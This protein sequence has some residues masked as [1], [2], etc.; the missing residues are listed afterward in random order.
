MK[1]ISMYIYMCSF[2][3][4]W[5]KK[6]LNHQ[7]CI[8]GNSIAFNMHTYPLSTQHLRNFLSLNLDKDCH[9]VLTKKILNNY[10]SIYHIS[11][12]WIRIWF[13]IWISKFAALSGQWWR[14]YMREKFSSE[15]KNHKQ[16]NITWMKINLFCRLIFG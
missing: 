9:V 13:I 2:S 12:S 3:S 5:K 8:P 4:N 7:A 14:L 11:Q 1:I 6:I 16:T 10:Q 15:T